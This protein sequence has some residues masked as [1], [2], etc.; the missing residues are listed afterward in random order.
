MQYERKNDSGGGFMS[1][2]KNTQTLTERKLKK[3]LFMG[4]MM[5]PA[6]IGFLVFYVYVNFDSMLMAFRVT[7][8]GV[9]KFGFGN[10]SY[11]F[12][13]L[14]NPM[15]VFPE[16]IRNTGIFFLLSFAVLF[17]SLLVA[18]FVYKKT[19]GYK[20]FRFIF[21]LPCIIMSTATA[22]LFYYVTRSEG[23]VDVIYR[24][25]MNG[26]ALPS[27]WNEPGTANKM[28][29]FYTVFYGVGGNM[30]LLL[31]AMSNISPEIFEAAR[32]DGVGWVRELFQ[33]IIPLIW[34]TLS[35]ILLQLITAL[36]QASGPVF[37]FTKGKAGTT[38]LS[39][40]LY[41]RLLEGSM[42]E[43]SAAIGWCCTMFTFPIAL[44]AKRILNKIE[45][46]IGA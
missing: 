8:D 17:F 1:V 46:K 38:T 4:A 43:V 42:L 25:L 36:T 18:Y 3:G 19:P 45:D 5:L 32:L 12:K 44:L 10:F 29:A 33:L 6:T 9:E 15:S 22:S 20:A 13:E 7:E 26:E 41:A 23:T 2:K 14:S 28:L 11:F 16:A 30:I 40:W 31:G 27:L 35:V 21:Y 24:A 34:P 37:L 39:Y